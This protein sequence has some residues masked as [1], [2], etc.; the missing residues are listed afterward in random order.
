MDL[1]AYFFVTLIDYHLKPVVLHSNITLF[2]GEASLHTRDIGNSYSTADGNNSFAHSSD[3][4]RNPVPV[5]L[6]STHWI[7]HECSSETYSETG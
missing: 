1:V 2:C 4:D 5:P 6:P 7:C 3:E